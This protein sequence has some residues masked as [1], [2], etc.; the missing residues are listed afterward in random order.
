[1]IFLNRYFPEVDYSSFSL[2][3]EQ[4]VALKNYEKSKLW[5]TVDILMVGLGNLEEQVKNR[6]VRNYN[7]KNKIT[8]ILEFNCELIEWN[9]WEDKQIW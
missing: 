2:T 5:K 6:N 7:I 3:P 1:M 8:N 9:F 4:V